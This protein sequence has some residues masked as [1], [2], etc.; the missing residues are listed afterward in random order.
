[1]DSQ[2]LVNELDLFLR[3]Y[4]KSL[5]LVL[6]ELIYRYEGGNLILRV[7]AD[8]PSGGINMDECAMLNRNLGSFLDEKNMIKDKYILE[9]S[10]PGLDRPL[11]V[12]DDFLRCL[13][14][15]ARFFLNEAVG[16]RIEWDGFIETA[17]EKSVFIKTK[18]GFIE[19]PYLRINKSR[20]II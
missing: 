12:R 19:V 20:L 4:L 7:L 8:K 3:D 13:N 11:K 15:N 6:V 2:K 18:E 16:G 9:V 5:D 17:G 1:M 10:S 14:K